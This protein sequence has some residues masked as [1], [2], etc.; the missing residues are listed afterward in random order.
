MSEAEK[1]LGLS[2]SHFKE[3]T[4]LSSPSLV[5]DYEIVRWDSFPDYAQ[6]FVA[7]GNVEARNISFIVTAQGNPMCKKLEILSDDLLDF[8]QKLHYSAF[9]TCIHGIRS[10]E[11]LEYDFSKN[12]IVIHNSEYE[13]TVRIVLNGKNIRDIKTIADP[14]GRYSC[15]LY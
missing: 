4:V 11:I 7:K 2:D 15:V 8:C 13:K 10:A 14:R 9:A 6:R 12:A 3:D 1:Y 5:I